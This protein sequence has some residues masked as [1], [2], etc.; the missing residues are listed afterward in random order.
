MIKNFKDFLFENEENRIDWREMEFSTT[1][2]KSV[3]DITEETFLGKDLTII[4]KGDVLFGK[5][6]Q[7][8]STGKSETILEITGNRLYLYS[9]PFEI[10]KWDTVGASPEDILDTCFIIQTKNINKV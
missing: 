3:S 2:E 4:C 8:I 5:L 10:I 7:M 9:T 6:E 1:G